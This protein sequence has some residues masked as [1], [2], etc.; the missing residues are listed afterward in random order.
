MSVGNKIHSFA[1]TFPILAIVGTVWVMMLFQIRVHY[2]QV[3]ERE[4]MS[5]GL[6]RLLS[7][8]LF[9]YK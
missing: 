9:C 5:L 1:Y 7:E 3:V 4:S 6:V 2:S 8:L